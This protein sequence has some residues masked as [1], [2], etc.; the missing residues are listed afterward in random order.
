[1]IPTETDN[2]EFVPFLK[3]ARVIP[4]PFTKFCSFHFLTLLSMYHFRVLFDPKPAIEIKCGRNDSLRTLLNTGIWG[5]SS[6]FSYMLG[7]FPLRSEIYIYGK[8]CNAVATIEVDRKQSPR[9][10][11]ILN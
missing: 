11:N 5:R 8:L 10:V 7:A 9:L 2:H 1:M 3:V 6:T 4:S